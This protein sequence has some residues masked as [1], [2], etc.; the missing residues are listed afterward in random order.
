MLVQLSAY[1]CSVIIIGIGNENFEG[2]Q[3]LDG[4]N[5]RLCDEKGNSVERD[6]VQFVEFNEAIKYGNLEEL[7]LKEIPG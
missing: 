4:D 7:V 2:M 1:P 3:E 5:Y 6:I